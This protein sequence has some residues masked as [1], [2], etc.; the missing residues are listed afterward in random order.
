MA[1]LEREPAL[2]AFAGALGE[3]LSG[4]TADTSSGGPKGICMVV[5]HW[6]TF[7]VSGTAFRR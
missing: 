7:D 1:L 3:A 2:E 4:E 5:G 6:L